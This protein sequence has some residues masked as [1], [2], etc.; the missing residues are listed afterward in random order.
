MSPAIWACSPFGNGSLA[1]G[2]GRSDG[3][4]VRVQSSCRL[5]RLGR[6]CRI[7][8]RG[9]DVL[10]A[11]GSMETA[12]DRLRLSPNTSGAGPAEAHF[13]LSVWS[14]GIRSVESPVWPPAVVYRLPAAVGIA[15]GIAVGPV[16]PVGRGAR[17]AAGSIRRVDGRPGGRAPPGTLGRVESDEVHRRRVRGRPGMIRRRWTWGR[18][19]D[20]DRRARA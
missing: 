4:G 13:L 16:G 18:A 14:T 1:R 7:E 10:T 3:E 15:V 17:R 20:Q 12:S 9:P 8:G 19:Q 11:Y 2:P 5:Y 6:Y